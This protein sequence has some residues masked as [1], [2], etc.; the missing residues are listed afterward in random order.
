[1]AERHNFHNHT[2]RSDGSHSIEEVKNFL[3]ADGVTKSAIADHNSIEALKGIQ[4]EADIYNGVEFSSGIFID[5][6]WEEVHILGYGFDIND[7]GIN[8][9]INDYN[10]ANTFYFMEMLQELAKVGVIIS[11]EVVTNLVQ[12]GVTLTNNHII[13]WLMEN[14]YGTKYGEIWGKYIQPIMDVK[15]NVR[16]D[17][18]LIIDTVKASGGHVIFA[19]PWRFNSIVQNPKLLN[20]W[21]NM[22]ID[23][24]EVVLDSEKYQAL[25]KYLKDNGLMYSVGTDFH[26]Y[27]SQKLGIDIPDLVLQDNQYFGNHIGRSR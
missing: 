7:P 10:D 18:Q 14:G 1:M 3:K 26:H 16:T 27:G 23:G 6:K 8:K 9:L 2:N 22:G 21:I 13:Y 19:H 4:D 5:G 20:K 12:S 17:L 25:L 11:P 24:T 15:P